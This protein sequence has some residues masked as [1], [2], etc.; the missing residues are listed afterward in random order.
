MKIKHLMVP[1]AGL[2]AWLCPGTLAAAPEPSA[3]PADTD[4]PAVKFVKSSH[5]FGYGKYTV[6]EIFERYKKC[7]PDSRKWEEQ[8]LDG[9]MTVIFTCLLPG[10]FE[11]A[12]QLPRELR[13]KLTEPV[14]TRILKAEF[15]VSVENDAFA[16]EYIG[17]GYGKNFYASNYTENQKNLDKVLDQEDFMSRLENLARHRETRAEFQKMIFNYFSAISVELP[18]DYNRWFYSWENNKYYYIKLEGFDWSPGPAPDMLTGTAVLSMAET[19]LTTDTILAH[20]K[21]KNIISAGYRK[22]LLGTLN[23]HPDALE[24]LH[25]RKGVPKQIRYACGVTISDVSKWLNISWLHT[26]GNSRFSLVPLDGAPKPIRM[27]LEL[28]N[29]DSVPELRFVRD[30]ELDQSI[31]DRFNFPGMR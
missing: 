2:W 12:D 5:F 6:G 14:F 8:K 4:P 26:G 21:Q 10:K 31:Q 30:N 9:G 1:A 23:E 24:D 18:D 15:A 22:D 17:M 3:S 7:A 29:L 13:L 25:Y 27:I 19:D 16:L 11:D 28:K 20:L